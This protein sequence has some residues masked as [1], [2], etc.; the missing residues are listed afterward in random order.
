MFR[1]A[2]AMCPQRDFEFDVVV[3][4]QNLT[5]V[6]PERRDTVLRITLSGSSMTASDALRHHVLETREAEK[7]QLVFFGLHQCTC[8]LYPSFAALDADNAKGYPPHVHR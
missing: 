2:L 4:L 8:R 7:Y 3:R 1:Q 5:F 6:Y